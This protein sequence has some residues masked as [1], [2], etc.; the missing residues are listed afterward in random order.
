MEYARRYN[1]DKYIDVSV[2]YAVWRKMEENLL[3]RK[4]RLLIT[5][6]DIINELGI[7]RLSTREIARRQ[8]ISEATL[9]RHFK[10]KNALL[11]AVLDFFCQFDD[12]IFQ[13]TKLRGLT[14]RDSI[15]FYISSLS[16]Y[17]ENYPA[18]TSIMQLFDVLR[19]EITLAPK[20]EYIMLQRENHLQTLLEDAR[21]SGEL[22]AELDCRH[23]SVTISGICREVCLKWR[24]DDR[25]YSL[26]EK[27]MDIMNTMLAAFFTAA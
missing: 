14:A 20:I 26:K 4:E 15:W 6:I 7:Q 10:N 24:M 9:F 2:H 16:E 12:D 3:H 8:N 5:T 13:T 11:E 23:L 1:E 18:I 27:T 17:Y 25:K 21:S 19:Y 22:S